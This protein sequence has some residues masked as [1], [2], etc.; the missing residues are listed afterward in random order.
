MGAEDGE[1][2]GNEMEDGEVKGA[3]VE[4]DEEAAEQGE[5]T[6]SDEEM[7][8][9]EGDAD[10]KEVEVAVEDDK[11]V[12]DLD[13]AEDVEKTTADILSRYSQIGEPK[14]HKIEETVETKKES[15]E[16]KIKVDDAATIDVETENKTTKA[17][18]TPAKVV[19]D[20]SDL[21]SLY[22]QIKQFQ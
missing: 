11:V 18:E 14:K 19:L 6:D 8:M 22:K 9:E 21:G 3:E 12:G 5:A 13:I 20:F 7:P 15:P 17:E 4:D 16:K 1:V 2:K 10:E